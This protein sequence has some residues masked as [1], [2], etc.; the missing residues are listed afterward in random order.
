MEGC[1]CENFRFMYKRPEEIGQNFLVRR[2]GFDVTQWRPL[3][4]CKHPHAV[5]DPIRTKCKECGC[6]K[7]I[8]NFACLSCDGKWEEHVTTYEDE[9][10]RKELGKLVGN[11][12]YPLSD[13]PEIQ[14]EFIRQLEEEKQKQSE[15]K[16]SENSSQ[17]I[18]TLATAMNQVAIN[19]GN[20]TT[21]ATLEQRQANTLP[22]REKPERSVRLMKEKGMLRKY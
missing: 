9:E 2:K 17:E 5:H 16:K 14:A 3:C 13:V 8:S 21:I 15:D 12:F 6:G 11:D 18:S 19:D 1:K 22:A 20:G 10:L 4:K 7:F